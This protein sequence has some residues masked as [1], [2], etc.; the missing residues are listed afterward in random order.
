M[1]SQG[2][3]LWLWLLFGRLL[4]NWSTAEEAVTECKGSGHGEM[5]EQWAVWGRRWCE[6]GQRQAVRGRRQRKIL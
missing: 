5:A 1:D 4:V 3:V 2:L 6:T